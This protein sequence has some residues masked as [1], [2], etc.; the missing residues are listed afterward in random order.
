MTNPYIPKLMRIVD[1]G[2][3]DGVDDLKSFYPFCY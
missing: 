3:E 2:S 1:I